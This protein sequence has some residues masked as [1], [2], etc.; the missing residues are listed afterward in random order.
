MA[1]TGTPRDVVKKLNAQVMAALQ[2]PAVREQLDTMAMR[3]RYQSAEESSA[4]L[5]Q[6]MEAWRDLVK[7]S[8]VTLN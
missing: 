7:L 8:G 5:K 1:P 4:F 6:D 3:T 2:A